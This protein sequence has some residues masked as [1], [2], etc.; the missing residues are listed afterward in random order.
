MEIIEL[1]RLLDSEQRI[2][3]SIDNLIKQKEWI[4]QDIADL[5]TSLRKLRIKIMEIQS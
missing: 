3:N 1:D 5:R 2:R 4:T